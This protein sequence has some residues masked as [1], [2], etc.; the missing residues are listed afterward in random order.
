MR[1]KEKKEAESKIVENI[2]ENSVYHS[3]VHR[4]ETRFM[5]DIGQGLL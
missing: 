3:R 1:T 4:K 2:N 5:I